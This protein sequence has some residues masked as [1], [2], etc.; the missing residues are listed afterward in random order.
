MKRLLKVSSVPRGANFSGGRGAISQGVL[1]NEIHD[2]SYSLIHFHFLQIPYLS[3]DPLLYDF[4]NKKKFL[5]CNFLLS[6][7]FLIMIAII[8][9]AKKPLK[10]VLSPSSE[11][12]VS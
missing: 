8:F 11:W 7:T 4:E 6:K 10:M 3:N 2:T 12:T 9:I 5:C 1:E